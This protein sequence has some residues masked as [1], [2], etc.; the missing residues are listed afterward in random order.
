MITRAW[1]TACCV[2]LPLVGG[3]AAVADEQGF[4]PTHD[5]YQLY[6]RKVGSGPEAVLIPISVFTFDGLSSLARPKR[7]LVFYDPRNRGRSQAVGDLS[8]FTVE[9][10]V[11]DMETLR[12]HFGFERISLVG[13]SVY[14]MEVVL[15]AVEHPTR[16]QRLVQLGPVPL[17]Y[18]TAYPRELDNTSD[19]SVFDQVLWKRLQGLEA[20]HKD[21]TEPKEYC[22][23]SQEFYKVGLVTSPGALVRL[24]PTV[25]R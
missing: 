1:S 21:S 20:E 9:N 10:D 22:R 5:G 14:G 17:K 11:R 16:V 2:L 7:T 3:C 4:V 18:G 8:T 15:Y 6:Y 12:E 24:Q 19:R 25:D 13:Y 23:I